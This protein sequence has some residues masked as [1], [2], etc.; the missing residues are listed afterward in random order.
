[1]F[2]IREDNAAVEEKL[3]HAGAKLGYRNKVGLGTGWWSQ[4]RT[5]TQIRTYGAADM[6]T[7]THFI[8]IATMAIVD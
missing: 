2:A 6:Y 4:V 5:H 8:T 7:H 1:M 3:I